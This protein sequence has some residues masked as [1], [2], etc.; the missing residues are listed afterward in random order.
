MDQLKT[1]L[2]DKFQSIQEREIEVGSTQIGPQRDD[3]KL[4]INDK[5]VQQYGSQGQQR[6]TVLS[7]KLAEIEC[8]HETLGEY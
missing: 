3:L 4:M 2:M 5:V 8:M 6:T 1:E 7:L